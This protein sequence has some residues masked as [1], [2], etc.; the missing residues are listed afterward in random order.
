MAVHRIKKNYLFVTGFIVSVKHRGEVR[1]WEGTLEW[2]FLL[3][4]DQDDA[5]ASYQDH[6]PITYKK[7]NGKEGTYTVDVVV[8][9]RSGQVVYYEVKPLDDDSEGTA[10]FRRSRKFKTLR[11]TLRTDRVKYRGA[12]RY[13]RDHGAVFKFLKPRQVPKDLVQ[14]CKFL[15]P[16]FFRS[17]SS[18]LIDALLTTMQE[19]IESTPQQLVDALARTDEEK[20]LLYPVLW[21]LIGQKKI[22]ADWYQPLTNTA[23]IWID[24][25]GTCADSR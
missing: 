13:A 24:K 23:R 5:V 18:E 21:Q 4:L 20:I 17:F 10:K 19:L 3:V 9:Y 25:E 15:K 8:T 11:E 7:A 2:A 14:N 1:Y 6:V 16:F 22:L 12:I